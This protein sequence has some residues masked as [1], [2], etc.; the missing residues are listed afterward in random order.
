MAQHTAQ[1]TAHRPIGYWVKEVDRLLE[2]RLDDVL[3]RHLLT[4]RHW[5]VLNTIAQGAATIADID[6]QLA[7]FRSERRTTVAPVV[8]DLRE[9]G[10]VAGHDGS[11]AL[12]PEGRTTFDAL[13]EEVSETRRRTVDGIDDA[14]YLTTIGVLEQMAGNLSASSPRTAAAQVTTRRPGR[15]RR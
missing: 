1:Q 6:E 2:S 8:A 3:A 4:R 7:P 13:L 9:R 15:P 14:D 5:Q 10:M 11:L 12:R